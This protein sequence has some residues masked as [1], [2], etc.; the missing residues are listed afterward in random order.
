M[1]RRRRAEE[2]ITQAKAVSKYHIEN[3]LW[4]KENLT[5]QYP[6]ILISYN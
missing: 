3:A 2:D 6:L 4:W 5:I 1:Q